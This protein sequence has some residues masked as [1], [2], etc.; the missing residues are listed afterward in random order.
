MAECNASYV[1]EVGDVITINEERFMCPELL[2]A[3]HLNG[4]GFEGIH[5]TIVKVINSYDMTLRKDLFANVVISGGNTMFSGLPERLSKEMTALAPPTAKVNV[6][7]PEDRGYGVW[8]GGCFFASL[9]TFS[10]MC[11]SAA[12]YKENGPGFVH[13]KFP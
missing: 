9:P 5:K 3:P 4:L 12:E 7:A 2:F 11:I 1:R 13:C 6:V 8:K 10:Q